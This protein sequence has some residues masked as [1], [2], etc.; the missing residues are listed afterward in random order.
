MKKES[1]SLAEALPLEQARVREVLG[2]YKE[3]GP[4]GMIGAAFIEQDLRQADQA[5]MSGDVIA[6]LKAYET[7][8]Q[9]KA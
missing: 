6:M 5:V 1:I 7:L 9:I 3:I 4:A 8:K 2:Y